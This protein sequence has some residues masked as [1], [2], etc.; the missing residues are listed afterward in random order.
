M[1]FSGSYTKDDV[2]FLLTVL[3]KKEL[4]STDPKEKERLIQTGKKHYSD[5]L[6]FE[7][8]PSNIHQALYQKS[9]KKYAQ[10]YAQNIHYLATALNVAFK[11]LNQDTPLVLVSL[12]RAGVPVGVLLKRAFDDKKMPYHKK[13]V[14]Y[15]VSIIRDKGIDKTAIKEILNTHPNAPLVFIDGWTGK[16]A[17]FNELKTSLDDLCF[18]LQDEFS[19]IKHR[20]FFNNSSD[21]EIVPLVVMSDP[22][23]VAWLSASFDDWLMPPSLLNSTVSGLISRTLYN[24]KGFHQCVYYDELTPYDES[25]NFVNAIDD[26]RKTLKISMSDDIIYHSTP[27]FSTKALIDNIAK[28]FNI[29]NYNRI[30]PTLAE[31]TRAVIRREP[32]CVI[33]DKG[34]MDNDDTRFLVHLCQEKQVKIIY[35]DILPYQAM[36]IIKKRN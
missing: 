2:R 26:I 13:A 18:E 14:H 33:L 29:D 12:V 1:Y 34:S 3:D 22:A 31:A 23:G 11:D 36:T 20:L 30:K 27:R 5:M 17:I 8:A 16:G 4:Q 35:Q 6:T 24:D 19:D 28:A 15:G 25:L 21:K 10:K 32:E 9:L 7:K